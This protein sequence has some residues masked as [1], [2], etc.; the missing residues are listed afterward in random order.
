MQQASHMFM[1]HFDSFNL[2]AEVIPAGAFSQEYPRDCRDRSHTG[3][4]QLRCSQT[5]QQALFKAL[6]Q[7]RVS[8][9]VGHSI[10]LGPQCLFEVMPRVSFVTVS[11]SSFSNSMQL[12][13]SLTYELQRHFNIAGI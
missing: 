5:T 4:V 13:H 7:E 8:E 11:L 10:V 2:S 1:N 3:L 12:Q 9:E 6:R